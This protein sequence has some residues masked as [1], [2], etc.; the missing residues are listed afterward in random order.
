MDASAW[1]ACSDELPDDEITV[2]GWL[3]GADDCERIYREDR[4]WFR[5][6]DADFVTDTV[7]HWQHLPEAPR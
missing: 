2:L 1:I 7:T 4:C 5:A 3:Q 6:L